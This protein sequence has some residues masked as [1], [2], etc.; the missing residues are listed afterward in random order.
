MEAWTQIIASVGFP[1]AISIYL[2]VYMQSELR[3]LTETILKLT[4]KIDKICN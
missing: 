2:L 4:E 3:Q 1:V